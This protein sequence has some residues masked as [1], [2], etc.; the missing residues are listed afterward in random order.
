M[1]RLSGKR[2]RITGAGCLGFNALTRLTICPV[3]E[4][5]LQSDKSGKMQ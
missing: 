5:G 1:A 4:M 3:I 2:A